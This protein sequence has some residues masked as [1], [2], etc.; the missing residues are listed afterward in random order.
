MSLRLPFVS[1]GYFPQLDIL[2]RVLRYEFYSVHFN[3]FSS[4]EL[5]ALVPG[6]SLLH[7]HLR[8]GLDEA[9]SVK[10]FELDRVERPFCCW[11][12]AW[13]DCAPTPSAFLV[14]PVSSV[15]FDL[16]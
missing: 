12:I 2:V 16:S 4:F 1:M 14:V 3:G 5:I 8:V 7:G 9:F 15:H 11:F 6:L 10:R 13:P